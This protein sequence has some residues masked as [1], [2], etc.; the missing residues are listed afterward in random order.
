MNIYPSLELPAR[1]QLAESSKEP[2]PELARESK[3]PNDAE[4]TRLRSKIRGSNWSAFWRALDLAYDAWTVSSSVVDIITGQ[5]VGQKV[6]VY[7]ILVNI[8]KHPPVK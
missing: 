5:F 3:T 8:S 1:P 2:D 7:A 6:S 4:T